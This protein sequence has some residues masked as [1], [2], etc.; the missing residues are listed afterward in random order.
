M[1]QVTN[2]ILKYTDKKSYNLYLILKN[3]L[4]IFI[5]VVFMKECRGRKSQ[6]F[7]YMQILYKIWFR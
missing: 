3:K 2:K 6:H 5:A 7:R 1:I 4:A